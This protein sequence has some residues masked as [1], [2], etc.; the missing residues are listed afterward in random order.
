MKVKNTFFQCFHI[1]KNSY[2]THLFCLKPKN[3]KKNNSNYTL[4][5]I[6]SKSILFSVSLIQQVPNRINKF[7]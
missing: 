5:L 7:G 1:Y 2:N 3:I 4:T 6:S